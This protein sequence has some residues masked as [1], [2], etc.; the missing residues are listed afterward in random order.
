MLKPEVH[1]DVVV[2]EQLGAVLMSMSILPPE[3][4]MRSMAHAEARDHV[5]VCGLCCCKNVCG[6]DLCSC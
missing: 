5:D 6:H 2:L 4:M 1:M 3:T